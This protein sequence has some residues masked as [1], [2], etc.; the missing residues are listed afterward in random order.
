MTGPAVAPTQGV[1]L[2]NVPGGGRVNLGDVTEVKRLQQSYTRDK[3]C[4]VT[5]THTS[6]GS[7]W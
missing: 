6:G 3:L 1:D 5:L 2:D 4:I 7:R